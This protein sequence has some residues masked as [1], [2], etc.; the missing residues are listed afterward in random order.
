[1]ANDEGAWTA[2]SYILLLGFMSTA[3]ATVLFNQLVKI[4]SPLYTSS[5]TYLIP[6]VAVL[7]G[8]FDGERL[9]AGHFI[10]M[11]AIIGG[12]YLANRK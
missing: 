12:V 10:G 5:V 8:L 4:S 7:W 11:L 1:M 3:L 9:L 2:L 6:V